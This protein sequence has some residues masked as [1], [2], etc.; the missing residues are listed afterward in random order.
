KARAHRTNGDTSH[1]V[2]I[3]ADD[4]EADISQF[5]TII[6]RTMVLWNFLNYIHQE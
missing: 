5:V 1:A 4:I 3:S 2:S 6:S